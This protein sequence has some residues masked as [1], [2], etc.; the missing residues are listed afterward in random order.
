MPEMIKLAG[1][2]RFFAMRG[3]PSGR[4]RQCLT[5]KAGQQKIAAIRAAAIEKFNVEGTPTFIVNGTKAEDAH[6]FATL[7][8]VLQQ[9]LGS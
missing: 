7:Q 1:L 2:D 3:V 4:V 9:A 8:P 5:D 6:D